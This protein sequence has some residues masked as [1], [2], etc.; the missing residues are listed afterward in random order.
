M[1]GTKTIFPPGFSLRLEGEHAGLWHI[2]RDK[3]GKPVETRIGPPLE[4]LG[5]T[6]DADSNEW[7]LSLAWHDLDGVRHSWA[8]PKSLLEGDPAEYRKRLACEGWS[9]EPNARARAKLAEY[10]A[11]VSPQARV[12]CVPRTGW[13]G[14]AFVFPD[15]TIAGGEALKENIVLQAQ[16]PHNPFARQGSLE[17]WQAGVAR[18]ALGNSRLMFAL[19][20]A[21]ASVLLEPCGQ[22]SGGFNFTGASSTGKTTALLLASTVWGRGSREGG[23]MNTWRATA[24]GLES[25]AV[26]HSDA[27]LALDEL[28]QAT[29]RTVSEA[30]YLLANSRGKNRARQDGTAKAAQNWRVMVL[31][32]GECG[33]AERIVEEGGTA[34]AGQQVRFLD[35]PADAGAGM[36]LFEDLHGHGDPS[37]FAASLQK[38]A[39]RTYGTAARAFIRKVQKQALEIGATWPEHCQVTMESLIDNNADGQALYSVQL[40]GRVRGGVG[41]PAL[42]PRRGLSGCGEVFPGLA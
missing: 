24:N 40:C 8:M 31:S 37:A 2:E 19:C 17:E 16:T 11:S 7:G 29:A 9:C 1:S 12:R 42:A 28:G 38:A 34:K 6:R 20:A 23:Y 27:L 10:L 26:L 15:E 4:V 14:A 32:T 3:D 33:L 39:S 18:P 36:G 22:E 30:A 25:V 35:I 21:F 13:H 41:H 5:L